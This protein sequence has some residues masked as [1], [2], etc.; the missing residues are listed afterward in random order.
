MVQQPIIFRFFSLKILRNETHIRMKWAKFAEIKA[1]SDEAKINNGCSKH[2]YSLV[3]GISP[4]CIPFCA[5][6]ENALRPQTSYDIWFYNEFM[7]FIWFLILFFIFN[8]SSS[9]TPILFPPAEQCFIYS[10][11]TIYLQENN[12]NVNILNFKFYNIRK[13]IPSKI[14]TIHTYFA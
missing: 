13:E 10:S 8:S 12:P 6:Y 5:Y 14:L 4:F 2:L 1:K 9:F 3:L 11:V 7:I